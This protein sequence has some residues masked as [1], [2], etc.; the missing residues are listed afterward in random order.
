M[1]LIS[2]IS[3]IRGTVGPGDENLNPKNFSNFVLAFGEFL[4][5]KNKKKK[6]KVVIG[7]DSRISGEMFLS[8]A[9]CNLNSIGIDVINFG[10]AT[11][12]SI[13]MGLIRDGADGGIIVS[14]SHN[15]ENWNALKLLNSK[16]EFLDKKSGEEIMKIA[17]E[18]NF[19]FVDVNSLGVKIDD[20]SCLGYH[21]KEILKQKLVEKN[22]ISK[23]N[24]KVVVD[25][26]N[27]VGSIAIPELLLSL[28]VKNIIVINQNAD[29][30]FNHDPEPVDK[31]L[32]QLSLAVKKVGADIGIAIDPDVDRLALVDE[33]GCFFGEE[34]TLIAVSKYILENFNIFKNK[35]KKSVV[36]NLSSSFALKDLAKD[37]N[38][39]CFYSSVGELNVVNKMKAVGA[40]CGG[41]GNGGII[42]PPL[43][44]GRD[45]LIGVALFLTYLAKS[46]K[47]V[48]DIKKDLPGYFL[49]KSKITLEK[50][51]DIEKKLELLE[52]KY[53]DCNINKIDGLKIIFNNKKSWAHLRKS[54]TEPIVRIY[55]EAPTEKEAKQLFLEI[56]NN[57]KI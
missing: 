34:Y 27:S 45:A 50:G 8:L 9:I 3:G 7:R 56:S 41:E 38:A 21:V 1:A 42:Y 22:A 4:K 57:F 40:V 6:I 13:E 33:N 15:P 54:N 5:K 53:K 51:V 55:C 43:H 48:S 2:S 29:G 44:Y 28:G 35:Y 32:K 25:G 18:G 10:M 26:I 11:T 14:S 39:K 23:K 19:S 52:K 12:P 20:N 30:I 36:S 37:Y 31:N 47:K 17:K 16:G 24:F 49:L 46:N